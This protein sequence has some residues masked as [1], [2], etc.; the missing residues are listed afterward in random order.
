LDSVILLFNPI[1]LRRYKD[2]AATPKK[3]DK[4][5]APAKTRAK[6]P[7]K[8]SAK[9]Q[10]KAKPAPKTASRVGA[11]YTCQDCGLLVVIDQDCDCGTIDLVCFG[12]P[13]KKKRAACAR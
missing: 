1:F 3:T 9:A 2:M 6:A 13:M 7:A 8:S 4:T 11:K 12:V 10:G 5:K